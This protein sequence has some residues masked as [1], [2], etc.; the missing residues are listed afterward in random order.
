MTP[1]GYTVL[2][3]GSGGVPFSTEGGTA[4]THGNYTVHTFTSSGNFVLNLVAPW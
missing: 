4:T 3:F 2:G 1:F